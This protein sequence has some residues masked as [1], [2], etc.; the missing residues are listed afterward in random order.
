MFELLLCELVQNTPEGKKIMR[1]NCNP[2]SDYSV[3]DTICVVLISYTRIVIN[4]G[5][6]QFAEFT[7]ASIQSQIE[8]LRM[9]TEV[10][11]SYRK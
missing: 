1:V 10:K 7:A 5:E 6:D 4:I 8:R 11:M 9:Y 2:F 3:L